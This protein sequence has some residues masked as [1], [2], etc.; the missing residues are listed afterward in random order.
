MSSYRTYRILARRLS[1][2]GFDVIR[3]D[4]DGTGNS[5]GH[6]E[7]AG[8]MAA[9]LLSLRHAMTEAR[10]CAGS[11][12]VCLVGLR[13]G[14]ILALQAAVD[15]AHVAGLVLW[16]PYSSGRA[17]VRELKAMARLTGQNEPESSQE[18]AGIRVDGY[19][20]TR[21]TVET[22]SVWTLDEAVRQCPAPEVLLIG[23]NDRTADAAT[24]THLKALGTSVTRVQEE[25]MADMLLP[26]HLSKVPA[27][28]VDAIEAWFGAYQNAPRDLPRTRAP[29]RTARFCQAILQGA[30]EH[31]VRFGPDN[32]LFGMLARP[33]NG[34]PNGAAVILFNT[35]A[36]HH[37]GPHRLYVPLARDWA[38]HGHVVLRFD[39]GGIGDSVPPPGNERA[40][41]ETE[42]MVQDAR[43]AIDFIRR[44]APGRNVIAV[45]LCSGGWL[46][47]QSARRGL[48]LDAFVSINAPLYLRESDK[49]WLRDGRTLGQY[50]QSLRDP[51][52]W[53]KAL[54]G[55]ASYSTFT[56]VVARALARRVAVRVSVAMPETMPDGLANDLAIIARRGIAGLFVFSRGDNGLAYFEQHV[57]SALLNGDLAGLVQHVVV[58]EAGHAFRPR[59]AQD[60]LIRLATDFVNAHTGSAPVPVEEPPRVARQAR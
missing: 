37:V 40:Y 48:P 59:G 60:H 2:L 47:F 27:A 42:H 50:Q 18:D 55:R 22:L 13:G 41:N 46:A 32:R 58:D 3:V 36:G 35:G 34:R 11:E 16:H 29:M 52:K 23:R 4:Y 39:L 12:T 28:V 26:P 7:D 21:D 15:D 25:G 14:S 53:I 10:R 1:A 31:P 38:S 9:W 24:E 54:R 30:A 6:A 19:V 56:R 17:Y 51:A 5:S 57:P 8:R 49:Q 44:E 33:Q 20:F 43:E 45:G